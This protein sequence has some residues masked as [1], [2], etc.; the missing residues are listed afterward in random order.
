VLRSIHK[1]MLTYTVHIE[2]ATEGGFNVYVPAL[3]GCQTQA[4]TLE[5]ALSRAKECIEGFLEALDN[6]GEGIPLESTARPV[7][8]PVRV[9][10]PHST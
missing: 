2:H 5:E 1:E 4:R 10:E 3:P 9:R 6:A 7:C 8:I